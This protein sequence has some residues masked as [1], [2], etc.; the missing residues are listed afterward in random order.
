MKNYFAIQLQ[1]TNAAFTE[2]GLPEEELVRILN[3]AAE[4]IADSG[5]RKV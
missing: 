1:T 3:T 4:R 5:R 2:Q